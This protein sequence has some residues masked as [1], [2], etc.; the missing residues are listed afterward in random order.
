M[1][2]PA[3]SP[4]GAVCDSRGFTLVELMVAMVAAI[5]FIGATIAIVGHTSRIYRAQEQVSDVQQD[6]RA[7]LDLMQRD[8]RLAG[9]NP[10]L[11]GASSG[12]AI[13]TATTT[14]FGFTMDLDNS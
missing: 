6:A 5:I 4:Y 1:R 7:A 12:A 2:I 8:M 11:D 3:Y 9:Y 13:N 10:F 14:Q